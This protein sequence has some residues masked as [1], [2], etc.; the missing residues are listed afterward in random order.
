M[1]DEKKIPEWIRQGVLS[2][3][4][5]AHERHPEFPSNPF[6]M[7]CIVS[8]ELGEATQALNDL[9]HHKA[10]TINDVMIELMQTAAVCMRMAEHLDKWNEKEEEGSDV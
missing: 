1:S 5:S 6:A 2:E 7:M 4:Q 9:I 8:E 3:Y 10:G